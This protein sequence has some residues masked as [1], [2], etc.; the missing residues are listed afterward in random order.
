MLRATLSSEKAMSDNR[1]TSWVLGIGLALTVVWAALA[2]FAV[3]PLIASAYRGESLPLLNAVIE[4]R[5]V[6]PL[7]KYLEEWARAARLGLAVLSG[8]TLLLALV[9]RI[10]F[11]RAADRLLRLRAQ[12]AETSMALGPNTARRRGINAW[13]LLLLCASMAC[14]VV[15]KEVW[16]FSHYDMYAAIR[17][18]NDFERHHLFGVLADSSEVE[19]DLLRQLTPFD[20]ARLHTALLRIKLWHGEA[21]VQRALQ[22]SYE[23]YELRRREGAHTGPPIVGMRYYRLDWQVDAW[24]RNRDQPRE[25]EL[26]AEVRRDG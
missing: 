19:I 23:L 25:R 7:S 1:L 13:I 8:G 14:I 12:D 10:E 21:A 15:G 9:T 6:H 24:A 26:I 22:A 5:D 17:T 4:G 18:E 20:M 16:P 3:P 2:Y 11:Q